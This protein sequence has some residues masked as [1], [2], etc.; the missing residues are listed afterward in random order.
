MLLRDHEHITHGTLVT[1]QRLI[2]RYVSSDPNRTEFDLWIVSVGGNGKQAYLIASELRAHCRWLRVIVPTHAE[3]AATMIVLAGDE[4]YMDVIASLGSLDAQWQRGEQSDLVCALDVVKSLDILGAQATKYLRHTTKRLMN[5]VEFTADQLLSFAADL[6]ER[7]VDKSDPL[8]MARVERELKQ[9]V[10][11]LA[12][13]LE[14][15]ACEVPAGFS[16]EKVANK[17]VYGFECHDQAIR[18]HHA[19]ALGL[20]IKDLNTY[21]YIDQLHEVYDKWFD[22][23][24]ATKPLIEVRQLDG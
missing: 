22:Q 4:I 16:A 10:R 15:R 6:F 14:A 12:E 24:D 18:R 3:S 5:S 17:F 9:P 11:Y 7:V 2:R 13:A 21:P 19:A 20:P 1:L 8:W 23:T